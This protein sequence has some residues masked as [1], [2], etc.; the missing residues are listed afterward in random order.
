ML[1]TRD[2]SGELV[3][4]KLPVAS[5]TPVDTS[6]ETPDD[7]ST[8]GNGVSVIGGNSPTSSTIAQGA[9]EDGGDGE[10]TYALTV[11]LATGAIVFAV[12]ASFFALWYYMSRRGDRSVRPKRS[13]GGRGKSSSAASSKKGASRFA[14]RLLHP[15]VL[16]LVHVCCIHVLHAFEYCASTS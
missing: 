3:T 12:M 15:L 9:E 1:P 11:I 4:V 8:G 2:D 14:V 5:E 7:P 10:N 13:E 16:P 6:D